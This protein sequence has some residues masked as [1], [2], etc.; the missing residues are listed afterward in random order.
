MTEKSGKISEL[1]ILDSKIEAYSDWAF[2]MR[3]HLQ[4]KKCYDVIEKSKPT[5][6]P[7]KLEYEEKDSKARDIITRYLGDYALQIAKRHENSAKGMWKELE[8][9]YLN[10]SATNQTNL[11]IKLLK[12]KMSEDDS[13]ESHLATMESIINDLRSA[14]VKGL[15][16]EQL[17]SIII[18]VSLP[19]SFESV[20]AAITM[21]AREEL[22]LH[23]IKP[24]L[25]DHR[26]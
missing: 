21:L 18:L 19:S 20:F 1:P 15:E 10:K 14:G 2:Q 3:M 8:D 23:L 9:S 13:L 12:T 17:A 6:A 22:Q 24:K 4:A 11:L 7:A 16:D 25:V 26:I 5:S